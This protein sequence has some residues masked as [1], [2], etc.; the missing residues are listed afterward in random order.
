MHV[1]LVMVHMRLGP[2][3][4]VAGPA[5]RPDIPMLVEPDAKADHA[6]NTGSVR[7]HA[8]QV[9][10]QQAFDPG[11]RRLYVSSESGGVTVF[12]EA[13]AGATGRR[14]VRDGDISMPHAHTVAVDPRSHLVYFPLENV[15]GRPILR[16]MR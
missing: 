2:L 4:E 10:E 7:R 1:A 8:K 12:T 11:W 16:I 5:R 14:L 15:N 13:G 6:G 9:A 3:D